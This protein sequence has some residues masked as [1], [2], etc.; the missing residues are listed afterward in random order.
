MKNFLVFI[1]IV[2]MMTSCAHKGVKTEL[3]SAEQD[4]LHR[5]SFMRYNSARHSDLLSQNNFLLTQLSL[6]HQ[7][8]SAKAF[9]NLKNQLNESEKDPYYWVVLANCYVLENEDK[10]ASFYYDTAL[11][12]APSLSLEALILNNQGL[13]SLKKRNYEKAVKLFTNALT[14]APQSK[15]AK[16][17][18]SQVYIQF[19]HLE[20]AHTILLLLKKEAPEDIDVLASL[21]TISLMKGENQK[22]IAYFESIPEEYRKRQDMAVHYSLALYQNQQWEKARAFMLKVGLMT[23]PYLRDIERSLSSLIDQKLKSFEKG[24]L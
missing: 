3:A 7:N 24:E 1:I 12:R 21:G 11:K 14:K 17:N 6:C 20:K 16:F 15:T 19:G 10:K 8:Q 2:F 9:T 5:E 18:L 23:S 4:S 22:A 13:L